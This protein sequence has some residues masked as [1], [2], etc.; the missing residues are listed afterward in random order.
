MFRPVRT[1]ILITFAF[2]AGVFYERSN[3]TERCHDSGG[4][5]DDGICYAGGGS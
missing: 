4:Q 1:L 3:Q 5:I 2:L